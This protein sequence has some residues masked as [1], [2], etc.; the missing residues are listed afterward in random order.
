MSEPETTERNRE[1][2]TWQDRE[3]D[4]KRSRQ[5]EID[6]DRERNQEGK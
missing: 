6:R 4:R 3:A 1:Q 2:K 5:T